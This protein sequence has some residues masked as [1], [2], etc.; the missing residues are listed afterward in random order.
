M[1][2]SRKSINK[3]LVRKMWSTHPMEY[4]LTVKKNEVMSFT[5]E[6]S[7]LEIGTTCV[8]LRKTGAASSPHVWDLLD[9]WGMRE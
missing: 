4:Y 2:P 5:G 6:T 1:G 8:R 3:I 7:E 9:S